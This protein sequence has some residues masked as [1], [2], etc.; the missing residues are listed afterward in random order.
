MAITKK[1]VLHLAKLSRLEITDEEAGDL[2][3]DLNKILD[4]V[5]ELEKINPVECL[6]SES[7][8]VNVL[9]VSDVFKTA[10]QENQTRKDII[11]LDYK[12]RKAEMLGKILKE[13]PQLEGGYFKVPPILENRK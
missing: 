3:M 9:A 8:G 2:K 7:N 4:Y 13:A 11:E 12:G 1:E 10:W 5:A 6:R